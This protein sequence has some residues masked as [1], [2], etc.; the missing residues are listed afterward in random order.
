[1]DSRSKRSSGPGEFNRSGPE[2]PSLGG[3]KLALSWLTE[4]VL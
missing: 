4:L 3:A 1:M 2:G